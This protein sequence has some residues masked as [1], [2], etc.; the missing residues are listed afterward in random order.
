MTIL[1]DAVA[2]VESGTDYAAMRFEAVTFQNKPAWIEKSVAR[3]MYC[4]GGSPK[5]DATTAL[6]I[7]CTSWGAFQI[8]GANIWSGTY[9]GTIFDFANNIE[10]Q[11]N[12]FSAFITPRGFHI[13]DQISSWENS[14]GLEFASFYNGPGNPAAYW[15]ALKAA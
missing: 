5:C 3:I 6:M 1:L 15:A 9:A 13:N 10:A 11:T 7:A 8:L 12:V 2:K 14:E 4:H